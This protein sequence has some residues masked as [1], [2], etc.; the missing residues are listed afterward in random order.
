[1]GRFGG[2][3]VLRM[4]FRGLSV[5]VLP[6]IA[7]IGLSGLYLSHPDMFERALP[8]PTYDE[9]LFD[10]WPNPAPL[11]EDGARMVAQAALP[12][13][14]FTLRSADSYH[15]RPVYTF[16]APEGRVIVARETGHYWVKTVYTRTTYDP[17][18]RSLERKIYW[19]DLARSLHAK[20][21]LSDR[22]GTWPADIAGVV[23]IVYAV[24]GLVMV[25]TGG[26]RAPGG[27]R[28][29]R[30]TRTKVTTPRPERLRAGR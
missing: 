12:G 4:L 19:A 7:L 30:P 8:S 26:R 10:A 25:F 17:N 27:P 16:D 9:S 22:L 23:L 15:D 21:W 13:A 18:G 29:M 24:L 20:G 28:P 6:W 14:Q 5:I 3:S 11:T 1:M 2:A